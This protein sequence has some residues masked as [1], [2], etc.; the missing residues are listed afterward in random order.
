MPLSTA[1]TFT[2]IGVGLQVTAFAPAI[3]NELFVKNNK[4]I[5]ETTKTIELEGEPEIIDISE[6]M[7]LYKHTNDLEDDPVIIN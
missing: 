5:G 1:I 3:I 7:D 2:G 6:S 4:T